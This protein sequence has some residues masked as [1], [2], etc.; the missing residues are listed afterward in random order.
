MVSREEEGL[1]TYY[2]LNGLR[3]KADADANQAI[4]AK[5]MK[6]YL[7]EKVPYRAQRMH[8]RKQTPQVVGQNLDRVLVRYDGAT[9]AHPEA[10]LPVTTTGVQQSVKKALSLPDGAQKVTDVSSSEDL[11]RGDVIISVNGTELGPD[12]SLAQIVDGHAPGDTLKLGIL[13]GDQNQTVAVTLT[14]K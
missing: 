14:A 7:T 5:E 8:S 4:T 10:R 11:K 12:R 9:S 1:F 13:R 6:S 3:G 2:F